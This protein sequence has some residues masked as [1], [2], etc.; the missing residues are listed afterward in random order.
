MIVTSGPFEDLSQLKLVPGQIM[1]VVHWAKEAINSETKHLHSERHLNRSI[2]ISN[3]LG[4]IPLA[5]LQ[6]AQLLHENDITFSDSLKWVQLGQ[7]RRDL[8]EDFEHVDLSAN[9]LTLPAKGSLGVSWAM[10]RLSPEAKAV[11]DVLS[12]LDPDKIDQGILKELSHIGSEHDLEGF[13]KSLRP[14]LGR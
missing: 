3:I 1:E 4:A 9:Y 14:L 13:P 2:E 12:F 11:A 6:S 7:E 5:L 8:I 10:R